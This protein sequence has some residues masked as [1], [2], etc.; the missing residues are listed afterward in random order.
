RV[1]WRTEQKLLAAPY[2]KIVFPSAY[3]DWIEPVYQ[4]EAWGNEPEHVETGFAAYV[5]R[6][7]QKHFAAKQMIQQAFEIT[8]FSDSDEK[9]VAVT[10]DD[11]MGLTIIPY[12][13]SPQGRRLLDG[14][15]V[16][17]MEESCRA[18][19]L[20]MNAIN[21]PARWGLWLMEVLEKD[22]EGRQWLEMNPKEG[23]FERE[24]KKMVLRYRRETGLE[25]TK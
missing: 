7:W 5:D 25:R 22:D 19:E 6:V 24:A 3:R 11:E 1:L 10:R 20:A 17:A 2:G 15:L 12:M 23:G 21:V 18:E 13:N 16:D 14:E 8:P 9:V 4:E